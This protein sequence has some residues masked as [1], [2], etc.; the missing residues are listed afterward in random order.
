MT[1]KCYGYVTVLYFF[2]YFLRR[3][4]EWKPKKQVHL[5][6]GYDIISFNTLVLYP[7]LISRFNLCGMSFRAKCFAR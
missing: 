5:Q 3:I 4:A 1:T 7:T 6:T 2:Y